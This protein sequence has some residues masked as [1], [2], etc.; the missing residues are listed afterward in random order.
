MPGIT[1]DISISLTELVTAFNT[2]WT[3]DQR[4]EL[5][6]GLDLEDSKVSMQTVALI[7]NK[8]D[9]KELTTIQLMILDDAVKRFNE[10]IEDEKKSRLK[11]ELENS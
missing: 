9:L 11:E 2:A 3:K 1:K 6:M 8:L 7:L 4:L 5:L 10:S